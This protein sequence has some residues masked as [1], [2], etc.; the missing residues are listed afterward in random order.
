MEN[1][2]ALAAQAKFNGLERIKMI[3]LTPEEF[4]VEND[5]LT[6]SSKLKRHA[7]VK[8]HRAAIDKLYEQ[9]R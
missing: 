3:H 8:H 5:L 7:S 1:L 4:T 6:P 2:N 9:G